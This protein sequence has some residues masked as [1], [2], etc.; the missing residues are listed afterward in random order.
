[1]TGGSAPLPCRLCLHC[2][3]DRFLN[4]QV[5]THNGFQYRT[6]R[7][8]ACCRGGCGKEQWVKYNIMLH[9]YPAAWE[10]NESGP[11]TGTPEG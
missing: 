10:E 7:K 5:D 3:H 4:K 8:E 6:M 2:Y 9:G 1:V 11:S